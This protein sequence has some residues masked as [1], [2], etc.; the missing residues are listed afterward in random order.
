MRLAVCGLLALAIGISATPAR[1]CL[2]EQPD[3]RAIQ[4][5]DA[6]VH[7][8]LVAV[9]AGPAAAS[10]TPSGASSAASGANARAIYDF[11]ILDSVD[12]PLPAGSAVRVLQVMP[13]GMAN[14]PCG[15]HLTGDDVGKHFLVLLLRR[16]PVGDGVP[17]VVVTIA[18]ADTDPSAISAFAQLVADTRKDERSLTLDQAKAQAQALADAQ[19][20]TEAEQ[21]EDAL[22]DMGPKAVPGIRQV[23]D[24]PATLNQGR[25]EL[26]KLI[27]DLLPP[28]IEGVTTQPTTQP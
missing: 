21:A 7:A 22:R 12:G 17:Y 27:K 14:D 23:M 4:W 15:G 6:I 25:Q 19:D 2:R 16:P 11:R 20:D 10:A 9:A 3:R 26:A 13:P 18:P 8:Q 24:S 5:S 28:V 1:A